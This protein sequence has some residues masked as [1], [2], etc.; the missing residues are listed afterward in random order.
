M[1][2]E[3]DILIPGGAEGRAL[4]LDAPISFWGGIDPATS[5]IILA[6]HPQRGEKIAGVVL[7]VPELVGSSSSAAVMLE[8]CYAGL[9][10]TALL[11]GRRDAILP[12]GVLVAGQMGWDTVPVVALSELPFRTGDHVQIRDDGSVVCIDTPS[13][14]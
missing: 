10:P 4:R 3:G 9:A 12:V 14:Q 13:A 6:D 2:F 1:T 8:L 11:L 5:E 7:V